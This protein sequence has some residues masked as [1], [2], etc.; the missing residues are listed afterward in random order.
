[1]SKSETSADGEFDFEEERRRFNERW[2][3]P[4]PDAP[5]TSPAV[6]VAVDAQTAA[7]AKARPGSIRIATRDESGVTRLTGPRR[8]AMDVGGG[9][10]V[11]WIGWGYGL[12][13]PELWF[14]PNDA[15]QVR[16]RY[17]PL[18]ALKNEDD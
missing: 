16:H 15:P 12:S 7:N 2:A 14:T 10:A 3:A 11:G 1:M 18:D 6:V 13:S 5:A 4:I 8:F 9:S 17:N